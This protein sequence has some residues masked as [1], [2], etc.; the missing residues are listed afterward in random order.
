[1]AWSEGRCP[2]CGNEVYVPADDEKFFCPKCANE[3]YTQAAIAFRA[4]AAEP[5]QLA[6]EPAPVVASG[7]PAQVSKQPQVTTSQPAMGA[8][9]NAVSSQTAAKQ[10][11]AT[12]LLDSW[13]TSVG[14]FILG[15]VCSYGIAALAELWGTEALFCAALLFVG[16]IIY[17][18][19]G[20]YPSLFTARPDVRS[21]GAVSFLNAF[22][23]G[24]VFGALWNTC[25]TKRK[26]GVSQYVFLGLIAA[27][28]VAVVGF[29][30]WGQSG[31][32]EEYEARML[33]DD[34]SALVE[35]EEAKRHVIS[36]NPHHT[37]GNRLQSLESISFGYLNE[38]YKTQ[39]GVAGIKDRESA[40][41]LE[42][43]ALSQVFGGS[44]KARDA[45]IGSDDWTVSEQVQIDN[46]ADDVR[47]KGKWYR[48]DN[49]GYIHCWIVYSMDY[50]DAAN[51]KLEY[52]SVFISKTHE[53]H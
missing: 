10:N 11:T 26:K 18:T 25:L 51:P 23:G 41:E 8:E 17:W 15:L 34:P 39:W 2:I 20:G 9:P 45:L 40:L 12:P 29:S 49:G 38:V 19:L 4:S 3:V 32:S 43:L 30:Y 21:R 42:R 52:Y 53:Q 33:Y 14:M 16:G 44:A 28:C 36:D 7:Q 13:K 50:T 47:L 37:T 5:Q 48:L 6:A 1:M 24:I 35:T 22:F 27:M 31:F 46:Q